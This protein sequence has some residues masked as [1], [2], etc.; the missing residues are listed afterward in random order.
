MD[1]RPLM[2]RLPAN[3]SS[4]FLWSST[5]VRPPISKVFSMGQ[6]RKF[7]LSYLIIYVVFQLFAAR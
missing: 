7:S 1:G 2:T 4:A 6:Q 5:N 3:A